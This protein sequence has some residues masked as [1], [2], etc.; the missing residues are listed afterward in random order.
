MLHFKIYKVTFFLPLFFILFSSYTLFAQGIIAD[1]TC[2]DITKIPESAII[3]AKQK[4]HI[5]YGHTSHGSQI[6]SGMDGLVNFANNGGKGLSLAT[7]IFDFN[8]GGTNEAL[9][10]EEGDGY[11][12][13][14]MDHDC[15]YFPSWLNETRDYLNDASH[16]DVNVIMWSWCGQASG[17]SEQDMIDM[18]LAPMTQLETDF[19]KVTFV[20]MTGHS[21]G[22]GE[23]G[24]LHLRN[25]QIRKYC[26]DNNK[27]L[28]DFY[29]I[30]CYDPDNNYFG[31]KNVSDNCSYT[32]GNW[33][34]EWQNSHTEG[35]DW[36]NCGSAHSEPLNANQ[37]A[38]AAW[39]LWATIA[40]WNTASDIDTA[41]I[42]EEIEV[43]Q[44]C[45]NPAIH[46]TTIEF[47]VK[48]DTK[49]DFELFNVS[50]KQVFNTETKTY[51]PG[52]HE[53]ELET[54][55]LPSG[56]Y[57]YRFNSLNYTTVKKML[58]SK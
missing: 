39:W 58:V 8:N 21:D 11:G 54:G 46:T 24:K 45:P 49:I 41:E 15:G 17:R 34:T 35:S 48:K 20:Y 36:Y 23:T 43:K 37:K 52:S 2:T 14:W 4:L 55:G 29:D 10:L 5:A 38:Y 57:F 1:H 12:S 22:S 47:V 6:T 42:I 31:N 50:G 33:A 3:E 26:V 56:I 19:P 27:V 53:I 18:Y 40:G 30:E 32:G 9:D 44:N 51:L 25:Q 7:N 28:F 16:S 13:G